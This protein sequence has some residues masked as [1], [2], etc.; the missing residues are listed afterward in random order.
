M[1]ETSVL[2][3]MYARQSPSSIAWEPSEKPTPE[4]SKQHCLYIALPMLLGVLLTSIPLASILTLYLHNPCKC[5][6]STIIV[7]QLVHTRWK[8]INR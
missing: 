7:L 2:Q 8:R 5:K 3:Q 1:A 4:P 6:E